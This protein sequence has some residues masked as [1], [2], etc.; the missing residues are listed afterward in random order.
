MELIKCKNIY[1]SIAPGKEPKILAHVQGETGYWDGFQIREWE[2]SSIILN[3][4]AY[5]RHKGPFNICLLRNY[6]HSI[7]IKC[8]EDG[9][10]GYIC[11]AYILHSVDDH[12]YYVYLNDNHLRQMLDLLV[13]LRGNDKHSNPNTG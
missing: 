1:F 13:R 2:M 6:S 10:L 7:L 5:F 11:V 3:L 12:G 8:A 9:D 4:N